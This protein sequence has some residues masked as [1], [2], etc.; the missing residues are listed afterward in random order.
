MGQV[1]KTINGRTY[2]MSCNDGEEQRLSE[3]LSYVETHVSLLTEQF[4]QVGEDRLMLMASLMIA[5]ELWDLRDDLEENA[6]RAQE[7]LRALA[8]TGGGQ[9]LRESGDL[10]ASGDEFDDEHSQEDGEDDVA[11]AKTHGSVAST[12]MDIG[13]DNSAP[14]KQKRAYR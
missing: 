10:D 5:D 8:A 4:G 6:R 2:K 14:T 3:L 12:D 9:V 1:A 7:E 13:I 11:S